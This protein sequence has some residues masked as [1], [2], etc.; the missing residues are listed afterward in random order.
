MPVT[1]GTAAPRRSFGPH[2]SP[3]WRCC[4]PSD[5]SRLQGPAVSF[6]GLPASSLLHQP[7]GSFHLFIKPSCFPIPLPSSLLLHMPHFAS[8]YPWYPE[9]SMK[10][11][12]SKAKRQPTNPW[13][14]EPVAK[15]SGW[16]NRP[17]SRTTGRPRQG[18]IEQCSEYPEK[19][20]PGPLHGGGGGLEMGSE[21]GKSSDKKKRRSRRLPGC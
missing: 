9:I 20:K 21:D 13:P 2:H 11:E 14:N 15:T 19:A 16:R 3:T 7:P 17:N 18:R 8:V 4:Y 10:L 5:M 6:P 1:A 12:R